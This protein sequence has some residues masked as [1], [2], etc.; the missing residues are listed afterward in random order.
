ML[1]K[2]FI[3]LL[4]LSLIIK[5]ILLFKIFKKIRRNINNINTLYIK[6]NSRFGN[7]FISLN[8][9]I[10][11]C[12]FLGCKKILSNIKIFTLFFSKKI[13]KYS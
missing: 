7:Y 13:N 9:A 5:K 10:I 12:E 6:G 11:Y 3:I 4:F 1:L 2:I 8:N